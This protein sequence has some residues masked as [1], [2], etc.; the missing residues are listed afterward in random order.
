MKPFFFLLIFSSINCSFSHGDWRD[1]TGWATLEEWSTLINLPLENTS[2]VKAAMAEAGSNYIP[3]MSLSKFSNINTFVNVSASSDSASGHASTVATYFISNSNSLSPSTSELYLYQADNFINLLLSNPLNAYSYL[4]EDRNRQ[5]YDVMSHAYIANISDPAI[6][7][8]LMAGIDATVTA[9]E[10]LH[11]CGSSN[12]SA[13]APPQVWSYAYNTISVGQSSGG[14]GYG[15]VK[16]SYQ[17]SGRQKPEIVLPINTSSYATGAAA[18]MGARLKG[19]AQSH[20]SANEASK[21]LTIKSCILAGA[22]KTVFEDW[23]NNTS[24]PIDEKYG[25]GEANIY[26]SYRILSAS[27]Q[28]SDAIKQANEVTA[29]ADLY[30]WDHNTISDQTVRYTFS[31]PETV[32]NASVSANLSWE[33]QV[34]SPIEYSEAFGG[35]IYNHT[36]LELANL[37]LKLINSSNETI[38]HSN[39]PVDNLEH[40]WKSDLGPGQYTLE[41]ENHS[42]STTTYALAWRVDVTSSTVPSSIT[43]TA[44]E[45]QINFSGLNSSYPYYL[46]R[47]YDLDSWSPVT[48]LTSTED[49][50]I[51]YNEPNTGLGET[52]YYRLRYLSP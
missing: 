14:H 46:E 22:D 45:N 13:G 29:N 15:T 28:L 2:N 4:D 5:T 7:D 8:V 47:S 43:K 30:G 10:I 49:G 20:T 6:S 36:Y 48:E 44:S 3:D 26:F 41:I 37:S 19:L 12:T 18:S 31:V 40:I 25:A 1:D 32:T 42:E 34:S 52:V 17:G 39:S 50:S 16:D 38:F 33:R 27:K 51:S 23:D 21:A 35:T 11:F 9:S 24:R